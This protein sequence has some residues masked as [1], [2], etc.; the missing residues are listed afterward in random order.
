MTEPT[1]QP[2]SDD[3]T[4]SVLSHVSSTNEPI[5][6]P[7]CSWSKQQRYLFKHIVIN[8]YPEIYSSLGSAEKIRKDL[9]EKNL[10]R[11]NISVYAPDDEFKEFD[12]TPKPI[13]G[14]LGDDCYRTFEQAGRAKAHW[15]KSKK[16]H[17]S[18]LRK[19]NVELKKIE[20]AD[21]CKEEDWTEQFT[22]KEF[23]FGIEKFRRF[24][25]RMMVE[26]V[27]FLLSLPMNTGKPGLLE[28][29]QIFQFTDPTTIKGKKKLQEE[30]KRCSHFIHLLTV[31][32][33]KKYTF[34]FEWR[35][36][37]PFELTQSYEEAGLLPVGESYEEYKTKRLSSA[38]NKQ[39]QQLQDQEDAFAKRIELEKRKIL[40]A[41]KKEATEH[42][43]TLETIVETPIKVKRN[44]I[45]IPIPATG[46]LIQHL[47]ITQFPTLVSNTK[48]KRL[49]KT[50][51]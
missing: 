36:P 51:S 5:S 40:E 32:V 28:K 21:K 46:S 4:H 31:F 47:P 16:C 44:S 9:E 24:Q 13:Y 10:L 19:V 49:P 45:T 34:P 37:N 25:Y 30:Y 2:L 26:D 23:V 43:T 11:L 39:T 18:H 20:K 7:F 48:T 42:R 15:K 33:T 14:C 50:V 38:Q 41:M 35:L 3:E 8:H 6:C 12:R 22:E 29:Y 27:P 1:Q 17:A